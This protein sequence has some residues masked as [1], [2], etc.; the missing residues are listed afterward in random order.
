ME[1]RAPGITFKYWLIENQQLSIFVNYLLIYIK[2]YKQT[3]YIIEYNLRKLKKIFY[4]I[5]FLH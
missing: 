3:N 2:I 1:I 5:K 4:R